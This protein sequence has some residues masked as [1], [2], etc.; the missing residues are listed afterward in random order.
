MGARVPVGP[1]SE[2]RTAGRT[3]ATAPVLLYDRSL[4]RDVVAAIQA[5]SEPARLAVLGKV[6]RRTQT[7]RFDS[8]DHDACSVHR[9]V[10][11]AITRRQLRREKGVVG[12][13]GSGDA[14]KHVSIL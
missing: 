12:R 1:A 6:G 4:E 5:V 9:P 14:V 2:I 7:C 8:F 10:S 13:D 11:L 3:Y